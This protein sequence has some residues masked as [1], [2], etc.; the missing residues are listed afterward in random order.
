MNSKNLRHQERPCEADVQRLAP[1]GLRELDQRR[2]VHR[3][4]AIHEKI[5]P[6][7]GGLSRLDR[8]PAIRGPA[9]IQFDDLGLCV[10]QPGGEFPSEVT[11]H[12]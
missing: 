12:V 11:V 2:C 3:N 7:V 9:Y 10:A 8:L 5:E 4:R 6:A 1:T